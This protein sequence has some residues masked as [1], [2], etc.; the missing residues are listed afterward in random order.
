MHDTVDDMKP[1]NGRDDGGFTLIEVLLSLTIMT[2]GALTLLSVMA[3]TSEN[4]EQNRQR[5]TAVQAAYAQ[6]EE[7]L[8]FDD[9]ED[10]DN[11]IAQWTNPANSTFTVGELQ[12]PDV[13]GAP[14][15]GTIVLDATDT[16]RVL[17]TVTVRWQ[18]RQG[19]ARTVSLPFTKT[20]TLK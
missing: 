15:P 16:E 1:R 18:T 20:E 9:D 13:A 10:I 4:D 14:A 12:S 19:Q 7:V 3:T 11:F 17:V 5:A 8:A 6:M 2:A